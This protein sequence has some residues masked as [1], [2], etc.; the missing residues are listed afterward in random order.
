MFISEVNSFCRKSD[1]CQ[2]EEEDEVVKAEARE[3]G[4]EAGR[5]EERKG[6]TMFKCDQ[7]EVWGYELL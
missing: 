7:C 5:E 4:E 1:H 6:A 2:W 3:G